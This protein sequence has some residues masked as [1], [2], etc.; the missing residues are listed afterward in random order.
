[1]PTGD[2]PTTPRSI[3]NGITHG[4]D[5]D[6]T[7][8]RTLYTPCTL[9]YT[10]WYTVDS[11]HCCPCRTPRG[12]PSLYTVPAVHP[13]VHRPWST[14]YT[15][16]HPVVHR[17]WSPYPTVHP[18]G[19]P[20]LD[21]T[22]VHSVGQPTACTDRTFLLVLHVMAGLPHYGPVTDSSDAGVHRCGPAWINYFGH[23]WSNTAKRY[24][25]HGSSTTDCHSVDHR[26]RVPIGYFCPFGANL[27]LKHGVLGPLGH[28]LESV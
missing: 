24:L 25:E 7:H 5:T 13:V 22:A 2:R 6:R 1:M 17:P 3:T 26:H 21:P 19:T 11:V 15:V 10:P 23:N 16:V 20:S 8:C 9:P 14:P 12:T 28:W 27:Y 18:R 4:A